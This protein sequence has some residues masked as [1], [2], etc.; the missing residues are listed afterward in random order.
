MGTGTTRKA[1]TRFGAERTCPA[2]PLGGAA[3]ILRM[4]EFLKSEPFLEA[5]SN[6]RPY[7]FRNALPKTP[8]WDDVFRNLEKSIEENSLIKVVS[9]FSIVTHNGHKHLAA[10]AAFLEEIRKLDPA[11]TPSAH[12]YIGLTRFS[13]SFGKHRDNSDVF[14]WQILGSTNWKVYAQEGTRE[15]NLKIGDVLYVPRN[16][17]HE[18]TSLSPRAGISFGLDYGA[19]K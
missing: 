13:E 16:I 5:R 6:G 1:H 18:V 11:L 7:Y 2:S 8:S 12:V 10:A 3:N 4:Y 9:H 14:F 15:H 17:D 19:V